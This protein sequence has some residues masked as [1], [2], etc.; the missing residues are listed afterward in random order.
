MSLREERKQQSRQALLDATL[1]LSS[2]G[3]AFSSISLREITQAVGLVPAAF[4]R[5]F[6]NMDQLGLELLDQAA[7][8]IKG[9]LHQLG[10]TDFSLNQLADKVE[11]FFQKVDAYP[12]AWIFLSAERWGGCMFLRQGIEREIHY[13]VEDLLHGLQQ[14]PALQPLQ[15]PVELRALAQILLPVALNWAMDWIHLQ[16]QIHPASDQAA[17]AHFKVQCLTQLQLLFCGV[18]SSPSTRTADL[19]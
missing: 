5:H 6:K 11:L 14:I 16:T 17:F 19:Q 4:Y 3:R 1:V 13:L 15:S 7:L 18:L 12:Q 8:H 2:Q 10:P 9:V